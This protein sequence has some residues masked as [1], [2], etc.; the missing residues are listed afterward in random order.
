MNTVNLWCLLCFCCLFIFSFPIGVLAEVDE[1]DVVEEKL[2]QLN[3]EMTEQLQLD[4]LQDYWEGLQQEYGMYIE[5]LTTKSLID[6]IKDKESISFKSIARGGITFLLYEIISNGRLL[7]TLIV[8]SIFASILQTMLTAFEKSAINKIANF[9]IV[10]VL[11]YITLQTFFIAINYAKEAVEVM[12]GFIIALFPLMLGL[13]ASLG[14]F[15]QIAFFHPII[16]VL[17]H[18]SGLLLGKFV[19]PLLYLAALL[20]IVSEVND[21]FKATQLAQLIRTLSLATLGIYLSVFLTILSIQGTATAIQDGV[22]LKTTKFIASNFIPVIGQTLTDAADT[23]LSAGLLLKNAIGIVG[24]II[25]VLYALFPAIKIAVLA[26]IYKL[27]ASLLQPL[28]SNAVIK[29]LHTISQYM[30]YIL[31]CLFGITFTFFL[32]IV[33]IVAASNIPILLR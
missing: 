5:D 22:A 10:L 16:I 27:V 23:I 26:F 19:F 32:T 8:L 12:S 7:G 11:L 14:Q 33:I 4:E 9:V 31:A 2:E 17:I 13:I 28:G 30:V 15:T 20:I 3:A 6:L 18:F 24:L 29:S 1:Y 21:Q 25:I